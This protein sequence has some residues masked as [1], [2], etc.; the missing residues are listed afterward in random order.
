M[1]L[2]QL[3]NR[4]A[5]TSAM[6]FFA[7]ASSSVGAKAQIAIGGEFKLEQ[8]VIAGGAQVI[9]S[10]GQFNLSGTIGQGVAGQ[11][12]ANPPFSLYAGFWNASLPL[13]P[14]AATV[15]V[16][17]RVRTSDGRGI[18]NVLVT[19]RNSSGETQTVLSGVNGYFLFRDVAAGET[20]IFAAAA[21]HFQFNQPTF[22]RTI[23]EDTE[24]V[25]FV[26]DERREFTG[27]F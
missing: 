15:A 16:K 21:K 23:L 19:L 24:G 4:R 20:Y 12:A 9:S 14:T 26:A 25:D 6:L 5:L 7:L 8:S 10:G 11:N 27:Q 17:G 22:V 13:A 2:N 1:Q 18:R 3:K